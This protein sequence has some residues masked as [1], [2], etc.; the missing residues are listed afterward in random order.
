MKY[1]VIVLFQFTLPRGERLFRGLSLSFLVCFNSRSRV[2]S[3]Y[4]DDSKVHYDGVSI[5]APA[6]GATGDDGVEGGG[7][8]V[9]IHA[10]AWGATSRPRRSKRSAKFQFTLPRGERPVGPRR[11]RQPLGF[12]SRSRVGSDRYFAGCSPSTFRFNSRSRVGSDGADYLYP[13]LCEVSIHAPAWGATVGRGRRWRRNRGF[14]SRSR[15]G[16]DRRRSILR[17]LRGSFNSRSR[18]GSDTVYQRHRRNRAVS[19][20]APAW[21]ATAVL[22]GIGAAVE[23]SIHAPAWGAT[24][25]FSL[26]VNLSIVSIHAPAWGATQNDQP[27]DYDTKFQFTLPRGERPPPTPSPPTRNGFNSRSRVGSDTLV[28]YPHS[29]LS[30]FNSRSRVGSD[31]DVFGYQERYA[32]SIHAP[33]WGATMMCSVIKSATLFQFTLPRGERHE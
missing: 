19:I 24:R 18:V 25:T 11:P 12:N 21:G 6:W 29:P 16:S 5:H 2:G 13:F 26:L 15:V 32:V 17:W 28:H 31:N 4:G 30:S 22:A 33:A 8:L 9:S 23:V 27:R 14:N 3:D 20:H 1:V 10:P 7:G